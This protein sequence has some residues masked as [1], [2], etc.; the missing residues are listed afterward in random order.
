[1]LPKQ[2]NTFVG[3]THFTLHF[4]VDGKCW[5][6]TWYDKTNETW[7]EEPCAHVSIGKEVNTVYKPDKA[8]HP[9]AWLE[10]HGTIMLYETEEMCAHGTNKLMNVMVA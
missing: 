1:M 6:F 9:K 7:V 4:N 8:S 10:G 5:A 3:P 2:C